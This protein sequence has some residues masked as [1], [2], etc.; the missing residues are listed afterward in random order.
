MGVSTR[1]S[2]LFADYAIETAHLRGLFNELST[3]LGR[4]GLKPELNHYCELRGASS[5]I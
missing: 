1:L 4:V 5:R 3:Q 2:N